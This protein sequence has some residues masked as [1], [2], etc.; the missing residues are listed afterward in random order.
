MLKVVRHNLQVFVRLAALLV[1]LGL[2]TVPVECAAVYGPH[3]V[4]VSAESVAALRSSAAG[5]DAQAEPSP[6]M[7][8]AEPPAPGASHMPA[9]AASDSS[10]T[11][12]PAALQ[13]NEQGL[14]AGAPAT[15]GAMTDALIALALIESP[16]GI[17]AEVPQ[18]LPHPASQPV[19]HLLPAPEPPPP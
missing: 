10:R 19:S 3:S 16:T 4:F 17:A 12:A 9:H 6:H 8:M 7:H 11:P 14:R 5:S 2:G 1:L 15:A 18:P 13:D